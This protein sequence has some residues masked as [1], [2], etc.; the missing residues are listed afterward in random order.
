MIERELDKTDVQ[1]NTTTGTVVATDPALRSSG[2]KPEVAS[3]GKTARMP[4]AAESFLQ[5]AAYFADTLNDAERL[6]KYAAETGTEVDDNIRNHVLGAMAVGSNGWSEEMAS[7]LLSAVTKLSAQLRPAT[8]ESLKWYESARSTVHTYLWVAICLAAIIVPFSVASFVA[9]AISTA[10][11]TDITT[12]NDLAVRLRVQL[13][14]PLALAQVSPSPG[15]ADSVPSSSSEPANSAAPSAVALS[16]LNTTGIVTDLQQFAS[17]NRAID[18]RARQ[19]NVLLL[20]TVRDPFAKERKDPQALHGIFELPDGLPSFSD[21]T[22]R[23]TK[24]FKTVRYFAQNLLDD[25]SFYY[26][27]F[28]TVVLPVLYSL[29]GTCAYLLRSFETQMST[30]T[31]IPSENNLARFLIAGI[32]GA[33]VGLFNN[34]NITQGASIPPLALAFLVGYAVDVF[35]A[36]LE[37]LLQSFTRNVSGPSPPLAVGAR[38]PEK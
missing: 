19:L 1:L 16:S 30:K 36:F 34:L 31:F 15:H 24:T 9:S 2:A 32:G 37:S 3:D 12:G 5:P 14:P 20:R 6:L 35:F 28:T 13:G 27:A 33:V 25:V 17:I 29:L 26:G 7:N 4:N 11:R 23:V 18:A 38:A 8:P 21:A 22:Q 10:I